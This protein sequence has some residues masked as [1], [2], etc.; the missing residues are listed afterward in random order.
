LCVNRPDHHPMWRGALPWTSHGPSS[1]YINLISHFLCFFR[2]YSARIY[3]IETNSSLAI[4]Q[5]PH[6]SNPLDDTCAHS[7]DR[8]HGSAQ[9]KSRGRLACSSLSA[10]CSLDFNQPARWALVWWIP[11][12]FNMLSASYLCTRVATNPWV[13]L[14]AIS[15]RFLVVSHE[16]ARPTK[17][18]AVT[19]SCLNISAAHTKYCCCYTSDRYQLDKGIEWD[20]IL[21]RA[22]LSR[23]NEV[24]FQGNPKPECWSA[25]VALSY[26]FYILI[27][28]CL[29]CGFP[30]AIDVH[31]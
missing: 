22:P 21:S 27:Y 1:N 24:V 8:E 7:F 20:T 2:T 25:E 15:C 4:L 14:S 23:A 9:A 10:A 28:L 16:F 19:D 11:T 31:C 29:Q 6:P 26:C 3:F 30:Q 13:L 5:L 17:R 12:S 18:F